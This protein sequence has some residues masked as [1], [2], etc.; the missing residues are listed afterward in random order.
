MDQEIKPWGRLAL[1]FPG[2]GSQ[3]VGMGQRLAQVSK[4]ARDVFKRADEVLDRNLSKLCWEGP[5]EE[6]ESTITQF[7]N[8][9]R[10]SLEDRQKQ[11]RENGDDGN[12]DQQLNEGEGE[13]WCGVH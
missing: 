1:I 3:H 7:D 13:R 2:Q 6:L 12:Y 10:S 5:E 4:A 9:S 8:T 11:A